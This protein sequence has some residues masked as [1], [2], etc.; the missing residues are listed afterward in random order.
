MRVTIHPV[1]AKR[2]I[3]LEWATWPVCLPAG[4]KPTHTMRIA[5]ICVNG[6]LQTHLPWPAIT[7]GSR[8][9]LEAKEDVP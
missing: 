8:E 1:T 3:H 9:V 2:S 7:R 4:V 6:P 5:E